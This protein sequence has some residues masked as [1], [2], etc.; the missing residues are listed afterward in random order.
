MTISF[1]NCQRKAKAR[2]SE[3]AHPCGMIARKATERE[4]ADS[5]RE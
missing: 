5:R 3:E 4:E 2:A 1:G